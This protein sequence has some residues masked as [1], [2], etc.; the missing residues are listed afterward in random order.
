MA[1]DERRLIESFALI[2]A[3]RPIFDKYEGYEH[4][5]M[6]GTITAMGE[7]TSDVS[8]EL[9]SKNI[10]MV[11][12]PEEVFLNLWEGFKE[13]SNFHLLDPIAYKGFDLWVVAAPQHRA[14]RVTWIVF[15]V[16][17]SD[18]EEIQKTP[19]FSVVV[20]PV[21]GRSLDELTSHVSRV[22]EGLVRGAQFP[23]REGV[24]LVVDLS[25][26]F[27]KS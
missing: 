26:V 24:I 16:T 2:D 8:G 11:G 12:M 21:S 19:N 22:V 9:P 14:R 7:A 1:E 10:F 25:E 3:Y 27:K 15:P 17:E 20:V 6:P 5:V 13:T 23:S 4:R 18:F